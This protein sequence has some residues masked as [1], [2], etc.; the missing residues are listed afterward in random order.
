[1]TSTR[2]GELGPEYK[3]LNGTL[4]P[5]PS[6]IGWSAIFRNVLRDGRELSVETVPVNSTVLSTPSVF[7]RAVQVEVLGVFS[8][9][10]GGV[11]SDAAICEVWTSVWFELKGVAVSSVRSAVEISKVTVDGGEGEEIVAIEA[12]GIFVPGG[13]FVSVAGAVLVRSIQQCGG[14][15]SKQK[16]SVKQR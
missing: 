15:E 13:V 14:S 8:E 11:G 5:S 12:F 7:V 1:M 16:A 3:L 4:F 6:K 10:V 9:D 2:L